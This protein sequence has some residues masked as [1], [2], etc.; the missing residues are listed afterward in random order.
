MHLL[1]EVRKAQRSHTALLYA[2]IIGVI[3][4]MIAEHFNSKNSLKSAQNVAIDVETQL[5]ATKTLLEVQRESF[6]ADREYYENVRES[7]EFLYTRL[8]QVEQTCLK[9]GQQ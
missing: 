8:E 1:A 7:F 5:K 6:K 2:V 3:S 4:I 9:P